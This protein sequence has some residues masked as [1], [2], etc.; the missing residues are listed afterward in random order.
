M[1]WVIHHSQGYMPFNVRPQG[2][3]KHY[4]HQIENSWVCNKCVLRVWD[5]ITYV[6]LFSSY[7]VLRYNISLGNRNIIWL[8]Y[9][10][11]HLRMDDFNVNYRTCRSL[12]MI[13]NNNNILDFRVLLTI[14]QFYYSP[15]T[16][17]NILSYKWSFSIYTETI[18]C[19][20]M[21][22]AHVWIICKPIKMQSS[23]LYT[24]N[25]LV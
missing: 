8:I 10:L 21:A 20:K 4:K 1:V 19:T 7:Y 13:R 3:P 2:F 22:I 23:E 15:C 12:I 25:A 18:V 16:Y 6:P 17:G 9:T 5:L 11:W 14:K 24:H